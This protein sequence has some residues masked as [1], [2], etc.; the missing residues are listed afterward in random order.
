MLFDG[1]RR[2]DSIAFWCPWLMPGVD[3]LEEWGGD[4]TLSASFYRMK[5]LKV[6]PSDILLIFLTSSRS[7]LW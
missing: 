3:V 4:F 5:L 7:S 2:T 6:L 1:V